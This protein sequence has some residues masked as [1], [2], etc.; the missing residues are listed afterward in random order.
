MYDTC[1]YA[2]KLNCAQTERKDEFYRQMD[3]AMLANKP[4]AF[5]TGGLCP[6]HACECMKLREY[7]ERQQK[8]R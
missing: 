6:A 8:Q 7:N 4:V 1:P 5:V 2:I 3:E